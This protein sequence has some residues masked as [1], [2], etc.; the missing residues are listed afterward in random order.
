MNIINLESNSDL[1][2]FKSPNTPPPGSPF[3][4]LNEKVYFILTFKLF[5]KNIDVKN[6]YI[7]YNEIEKI[8][9]S[10]FYNQLMM[11][12]NIRDVTSD[13]LITSFIFTIDDMKH[14]NIANVF[15]TISNYIY[16]PNT[17]IKSLFFKD[18]IR[19]S[20][21][22]DP[23]I[24]SCIQLFIDEKLD[25]DTVILPVIVAHLKN[26]SY[27]NN[28][29]KI[30]QP[31][32]VQIERDIKRKIIQTSDSN[33]NKEPIEVVDTSTRKKIKFTSHH[34]DSE[35][36]F[37]IELLT[38]D[39]PM[40]KTLNSIQSDGIKEFFM[41][42]VQKSS[43]DCAPYVRMRTRNCFPIELLKDIIIQ[44]HFVEDFR[45]QEVRDS[46][47]EMLLFDL[48]KSKLLVNPRLYHQ[49]CWPRFLKLYYVNNYLTKLSIFNDFTMKSTKQKLELFNNLQN[50]LNGKVLSESDY[51]L[52]EEWR[53]KFQLYDRNR[54]DTSI[55][56]SI[57]DLFARNSSRMN[58]YLKEIVQDELLNS[59]IHRILNLIQSNRHPEFFFLDFT[60][61]DKGKL[62]VDINYIINNYDIYLS[63][64]PNINV[65]KFGF[66]IVN[67]GHFTCIYIDTIKNEIYFLN[68]L[69]KSIINSEEK[70]LINSVI[71]P[72][73][74]TYLGTHIIYDNIKISKHFKQRDNVSCGF[75]VTIYIALLVNDIGFEEIENDGKK[76]SNV[77][78]DKDFSRNLLFR[79]K[80]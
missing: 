10:I 66:F 8:I 65:T 73:I 56:I 42:L 7:I 21:M 49:Y 9:T 54:N 18:G 29:D 63:N 52:L 48:L 28:K 53:L 79:F 47:D 19:P 68:S 57:K 13:Y 15:C 17:K 44:L 62:N 30:S 61:D 25:L 71:L 12:K 27:M 2:F 20:W 58:D 26:N 60:G 76:L 78:S 75:F 11:E 55:L 46:N 77:C 16:S 31:Q 45:I 74:N 80:S 35:D 40:L 24:V 3:F 14:I 70:N 64:H 36:C 6:K 34:F 41:E 23:I 50:H 4:S 51:N 38:D 67:H 1:N 69:S 5:K 72:F 39:H 37:K 32:P 33:K 43:D 59:N 22:K